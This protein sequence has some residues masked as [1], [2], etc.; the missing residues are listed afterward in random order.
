MDDRIEKTLDYIEQNLDKPLDLRSLTEIANLSVP[1]FHRLFKAETGTTPF[2]LIEKIRME[3]AYQV[4]LT[5]S[6]KVHELAYA[7]N[8]KDYETFSRA[9]KKHFKMAP[10]NIRSI[11]VRINQEVPGVKQIMIEV[12]DDADEERI[13]AYINQLIKEKQLTDG[14]LEQAHF[15]MIREKTDSSVD[16]KI[17]IKNKYEM[18]SDEKIWNKIINSND[19]K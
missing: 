8:Y 13:I 7:L 11:S 17:L 15:F 6:K 5:G 4:L 18:Y 12:T 16:D 19:D 9:F 14:D 1:Q 10:D 2:Q 3:K